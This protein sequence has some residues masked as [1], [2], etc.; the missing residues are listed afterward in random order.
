MNHDPDPRPGHSERL[1]GDMEAV[2]N[3][4]PRSHAFGVWMSPARK[5]RLQIM[6]I[7]H[8]CRH[9][10][11]P[12]PYSTLVAN[13]GISERQARRL[14]NQGEIRAKRSSRV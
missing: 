1:Y 8:A 3:A 2:P 13:L 9:H 4:R 11:P 10:V 12:V 7:I 5:K 14:F 6:A